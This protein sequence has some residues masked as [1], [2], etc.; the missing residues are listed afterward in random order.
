VVAKTVNDQVR[1]K[2]NLAR[3]RGT[4]RARP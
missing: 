1:S 3:A 4:A 2:D